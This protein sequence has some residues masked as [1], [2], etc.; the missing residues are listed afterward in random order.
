[1]TRKLLIAALAVAAAAPAAAAAEPLNITSTPTLYPAF[2]ASIHDYV[3]RC[4]AS[5]PLELVVRVPSGG[6]ARVDGGRAHKKS[7]RRVLHLRTGQQTVVQSG[8]RAYRVR[9]LPPKFPTWS[10]QR[11]GPTQ[12]SYYLLTPSGDGP[13][14][15]LA[16]FDPNGVPIWWLQEPVA[17]INASLLPNG[18]VIWSRYWNGDQ[19]GQR[20][21]QAY[22]EQ[23]M[24]G[25]TVRVM[26][27]VGTPTDIHEFVRLANGHTLLDS[28]KRRNHVDLTSQGGPSDATVL[29]G[30]IQEID[31][32]GRVVWRWNSKDHI[33][34]A[35]RSAGGRLQDP[36][37]LRDGT[38]AYDIVHLNSIQPHDNGKRLLLSMRTP[39]ALYDIDRKT[40]KVVWK[41]GGTE[42]P[43][44]LRI[45]GDSRSGSHLSGQHDAR[46]L[47]DGTIT[48]HD[49]GTFLGLPPRALRFRIDEQAH[50]ATVL[51]Q[52]FD[53]EV[54]QSLFA[55]SARR[56]SGGN[57][58][59]S[60]GGTAVIRELTPAGVPVF[61]LKLADNWFSYRAFPVA[62]GRLRASGLRR[63][64]NRMHPRK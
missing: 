14:R 43:E 60:W 22:V 47:P 26:K 27:T 15:W 51:E 48:M 31:K 16:L 21:A 57:W 56:M 37:T 54:K 23:T 50:T 44:S 64:M 13:S 33:P 17:P 46:V 28:Y 4:A 42:T 30:V 1:M 55:G 34:L 29:D 25:R 62:R 11:S 7:F 39:S 40:G 24:T 38:K 10:S 41:L 5:R 59:V 58:V 20:S 45:V 52:V 63:D 32:R 9:C 3:S 35:Q 18:H 8:G 6:S 53:P 36:A 19:F 12:A 49:N 61:T 2:K